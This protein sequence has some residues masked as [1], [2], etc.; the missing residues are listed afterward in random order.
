MGYR[1]SKEQVYN[2][3]IWPEVTDSQKERITKTAQAIL[4]ARNLYP[5]S[6]LA[7]LYD[8]LTMPEE[9]QKAH[10]ANDKT[11]LDLYGL[12]ADATEEEIVAH[13]MDLYKKKIDELEPEKKTADNKK[14]RKSKTSLKS[15]TEK[16]DENKGQQAKSEKNNDNTVKSNEKT[17]Q[18][19]KK[20]E[21]VQTSLLDDLL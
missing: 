14:T 4:D 7:D 9:L 5:D 10:A 13:L 20:K 8:P 19:E 6:S 12:S 1:Y 18:N 17:P 16:Q 15:D 21:P 11:V 3:F 2:T